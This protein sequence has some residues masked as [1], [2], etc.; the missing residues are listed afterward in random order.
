MKECMKKCLRKNK[1]CN[2]DDCRYWINFEEDYNCSLISIEKNG[3]MTLQEVAKR[4]GM[5]ISSVNNV[6]KS[7]SNKMKTK[8]KQ[9]VF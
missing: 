3:N 2:V 8:L 1:F 5:S 9:V 7:A 6:Q 4:L